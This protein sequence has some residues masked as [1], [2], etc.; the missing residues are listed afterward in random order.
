MTD[1]PRK[2]MNEI[3]EIAQ[4]VSDTN[5]TLA[6]RQQQ[7]DQARCSPP[8]IMDSSKDPLGALFAPRQMS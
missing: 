2:R 5:K 1:K 7:A 6:Q 3:R 4:Q 8:A